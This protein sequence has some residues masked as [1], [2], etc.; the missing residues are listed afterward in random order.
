MKRREKNNRLVISGKACSLWSVARKPIEPKKRNE[1]SVSE[2][3]KR[4]KKK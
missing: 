4:G 2:E 3:E 1:S